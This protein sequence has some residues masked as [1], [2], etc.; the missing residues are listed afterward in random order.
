MST[1]DEETPEG[2][3]KNSL[4]KA[5]DVINAAVINTDTAKPY[6]THWLTWFFAAL[7]LIPTILGFAN[8]FLDLI[9]VVQGDEDGAFAI[10]PIVNY[11][12]ATAGFLCLLLWTASRGAF[13]D[14][15]RPSRTMFENEQKLD[16]MEELST[17]TK[18]ASEGQ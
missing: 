11:L 8:K 1:C 18:P 17:T 5:P 6:R 3:R 15:D 2:V 7:V 12:L 9:L 10:T 4:E 14:L 13:Q 16:A